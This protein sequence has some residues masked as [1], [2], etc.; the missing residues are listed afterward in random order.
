MGHGSLGAGGHKGP[1][2][3]GLLLLFVWASGG[4]DSTE[5]PLAPQA[6]EADT[7]GVGAGTDGEQ[8]GTAGALPCCR[9]RLLW[10]LRLF[11]CLLLDSTQMTR[12]AGG[13][14]V[15]RGA[16]SHAFSFSGFRLTDGQR[17]KRGG[18]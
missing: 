9:L 17:Q 10:G 18:E 2:R 1:V 16:I 11:L 3:G 14:S 8:G 6:M 13:R 7:V 15:L 4:R 12:N 5:P